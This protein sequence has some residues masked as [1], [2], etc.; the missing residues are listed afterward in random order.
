M[1]K[2]HLNAKKYR[3][4][5]EPLK[6]AVL[7]HPEGNPVYDYV[8]SKVERNFWVIP[9]KTWEKNQKIRKQKNV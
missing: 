2:T 8:K 3:E 7:Q 9:F 6:N 4:G 1:E 5:T